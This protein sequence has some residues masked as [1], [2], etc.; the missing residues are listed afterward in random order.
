MMA[1]NLS[2]EQRKLVVKQY[3]KTENAERVGKKWVE[4]F[5]TI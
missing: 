3:W 5:N 2:I 1:G 4:A